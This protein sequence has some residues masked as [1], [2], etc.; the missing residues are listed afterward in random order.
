MAAGHH[1]DELARLVDTAG[2]D[3][4]G[5]LVQLVRAPHPRFYVGEGKV[6]ELRLAIEKP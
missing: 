6:D 5:R 1:L 2:A 3:S 4:V